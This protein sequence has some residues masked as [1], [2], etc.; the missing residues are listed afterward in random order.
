MREQDEQEQGD[1][2]ANARRERPHH[3]LGRAAVVHHEVECARHAGNDQCE[4]DCNEDTHEEGRKKRVRYYLTMP[5]GSRRCFSM[6]KIRFWPA[7]AVLVVVAVTVRLGFWQR[8]R[9]HQKEALQARID[10]FK[11]ETPITLNGRKWPLAAIEFHSV[12]ARGRFVPE[13]T[14]YLDNR[15][16]NDQPG[17]YVVTPLALEAGGYVLVNRGWLPRNAQRRTVIAPYRTPSGNV[18][19]EGIARADASRAFELGQG[20]SAP[21][22][23]IR[24]NLDVASYATQTGLPL[25]PFVLQQTRDSADG[26]VRDWPAPETGVERNYGS[27]ALT[28]SSRSEPGSGAR[29]ARQAGIPAASDAPSSRRG[30]LRARWMLLLLAAICAAPVIASYLMYYVFRPTGGSTGYGQLVQP[31]RPIPAN[32]VVRDEAGHPVRLDSLKGK[33]LM[34]SV[35]S[36]ACDDACAK[37]LYFMR[38]V[39]A[40]QGAERERVLTVWLRTGDGAM[41]A[42]IVDAYPD[43]RKL[44]APPADIAAWLPSDPDVAGDSVAAHIYLIDPNGNLMMRFPRDPDPTR[45]K[46]DLTKLLKWSRIG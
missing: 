27:V 41:P 13:S 18:T 25:E 20:A 19:I 21:H 10:R 38:Q 4:R 36:S 39:R 2:Q 43:T 23:K 30:R 34:I 22:Q 8:D 32:L 14:V 37:K 45:I 31:Q 12:V 6:L 1:G 28:D 16:Y 3:P 11:H 5:G 40:T 17:F 9:A 35:D 44:I 24:Q 46:H 42:R 33:W 26:L 15:P 29:R 7:L